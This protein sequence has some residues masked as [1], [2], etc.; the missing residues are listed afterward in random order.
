MKNPLK[1]LKLKRRGIALLAGMHFFG[2][3]SKKL[4]IVGGT[5]TNGKTTTASLLYRIAMA[6]GYKAGLFST[7]ENI[8]VGEVVI[9]L[10]NKPIPG[11]TPDPI[12]LHQLLNKMAEKG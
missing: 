11:T 4:K 6:L 10:E 7:V 9:T 8:I 3:P 1:K 12:S 2:N 5:G